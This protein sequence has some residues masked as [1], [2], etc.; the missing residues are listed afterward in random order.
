MEINK[1]DGFPAV[2]PC[3]E[4]IPDG[5]KQL[6][7][8][9]WKAE[10]KTDKNG[11]VIPGKFNKAPLDPRSGMKKGAD[12]PENFGTYQQALDALDSGNFS[13]FGPILDG[14]GVV[15]FDIDDVRETLKAMPQA[16][17]WLG[18]AKKAGAYCEVSPSG[19]G[20]RL[21]LRG[22]LP[23][24]GRKVG[25]LEVYAKARFMTMTGKIVKGFG[26]D[27]IDGQELIDEFLEM[28]PAEAG[29]HAPVI[30]GSAAADPAQVEVI[31]KRVA[32]KQASLWA[33]EWER[34][35]TDFGATGYPSQSEADFA[36]LG[37]IT[38]EAVR[39]GVADESLPNTVMSVFE[40]SGLYREQ[41]HK[42][43]SEYAIPKLIA[44]ALTDGAEAVEQ[45]EQVTQ[46]PEGE[47]L[48]T[49]E[50]GDILAGKTFA[51]AMRSKLRYM[52]A[53]DKWLRWDGIRWAWCACGEEMA[54][55]KRVAGKV[56]E[57][58]S[59]LFASDP[60][61][62][63]KLM[64]FATSLQNLKRLQAM[65]ELAKSE[66]GMAIGHMSELDSDPWLLGVRNGV[67][68]LKDGGLLAPDPTMLITRQA[69][70][71]YHDGAPC[72]KW[73]DFLRQIFNDDQETISYIKRALGY[74]LT[75]TITEEALF[76]CFGYGANGKS[77]FSNVV[78]TIMG[79]YSCAA[80]ASLLTVRRA[81]DSGPRNDLARLCGARLVS[82]N[83]TQS[84]DR[85]DEQ[86][87]KTLAGREMISARFLHKEFFDFWPTAKPWLRT[88]HKPI[89]TGEDDGIW[90][91]LHLVPF[92]RKFAE[93]E[94]DPWLESKLLEERD[95]ILTWMVQGCLDWQRHKLKQSTSVRQESATYR[96]E[97][98]LLGEFL[99]EK[100][101]ANPEAR[102]EQTLLFDQYRN[103][104]EA[105]GT[106]AGSKNTFT[107]KMAER[108]YGTSKSTNKRFYTGIELPVSAL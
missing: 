52:G 7:W 93:H 107:K 53:A 62:Y 108:G 1:T 83:E 95:G 81:D 87:V 5:L 40:R 12:N 48:A 56:L 103:W 31:A 57:Q 8:A 22:N 4:N 97:S 28:L 30:L 16:K 26:T 35:E 10:P 20:L 90:R 33:G 68:N 105:N 65:I 106:R 69:A 19:K 24:Q 79:D 66:E 94:R 32:E 17:A 88:N 54:A 78:S 60:T 23:G 96:K 70:A 59:K 89:I 49:H 42:Q 15:S 91:R 38:R 85:L 104:H 67:V 43:V 13:G 74:T 2:L 36:M 41:K 14:R 76:I 102:V 34:V 98:D 21:Y 3:P 63:K 55:A 99:E 77:V 84:G 50:P 46:T 18:K 80:P 73:L 9:V 72:P 61:R 82:I 92:A 101:K 75:G 37:H 27:L 58:S 39:T 45:A 86:I 47:E 11:K 6:R 64:A 44:E 100:T 71:E 51:R 25:P 29:K